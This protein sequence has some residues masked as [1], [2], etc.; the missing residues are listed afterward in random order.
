MIKPKVHQHRIKV[1]LA[2]GD[3]ITARTHEEAWILATTNPLPVRV[4]ASK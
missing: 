4:R 3:T 1:I 2:N